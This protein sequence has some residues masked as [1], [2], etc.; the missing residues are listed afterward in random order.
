[1]KR[2]APWL[3][4]CHLPRVLGPKR[5][6]PLKLTAKKTNGTQC[7]PGRAETKIATL[8]SENPGPKNSRMEQLFLGGGFKYFL[9]SP[10][11]GEDSHFDEHIFQRGWFNHQLDFFSP[12]LASKNR[13]SLLQMNLNEHIIFRV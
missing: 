11:F 1:M 4:S 7:F 6:Q 5:Y 13:L 12:K 3:S 2:H 8:V 10:L 9:F